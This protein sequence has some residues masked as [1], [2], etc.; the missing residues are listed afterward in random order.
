MLIMITNKISRA[1]LLL[2][3][4]IVAVT[5]TVFASSV[6]NKTEAN[7]GDDRTVAESAPYQGESS[8]AL[9]PIDLTFVKTDVPQLIDQLNTSKYKAI[10]LDNE[11]VLRV[12]ND[13][14]IWISQDKG[15][16]WKKSDTESVNATDFA[17]WL[18]ENDPIPGYSM[19]E[20]QS[21]LASGA[22][23]QHI[24]FEYGKEMYVVVDGAGVQIELVQ[25]EKI[26]S[27]L[28]DAQRMMITSKGHPM[29]ISAQMMK[30]FYDLL[31]SNNILTETQAERDYQ[32]R[33]K[34][35][36]DDD[37]LFTVTN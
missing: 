25:P 18:L 22:K 10:Y 11:M 1:G 31:V 29:L 27:V 24:K 7:P 6:L 23:V 9:M 5:L 32:E 35:L 21:R 19:K 13:N 36:K 14:S 34:Q 3:I 26:A 33:I 20:M 12:S 16:T 30:S 8:S 28:I 17:K 37:T 4:V 15:R 2:A